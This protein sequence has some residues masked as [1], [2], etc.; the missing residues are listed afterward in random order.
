MAF[1]CVEFCRTLG[2]ETRQRILRLLADDGEKNVG[3]IVGA[4]Q[5]SQPTV[6]HHLTVLRRYGLVSR[7]KEGKQV[8]YAL[9]RDRVTECCGLLV[10]QFDAQEGACEG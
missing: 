6:S 8:F 1:D 7:R 3:E 10:A 2:D 9:N 4:C 5:V